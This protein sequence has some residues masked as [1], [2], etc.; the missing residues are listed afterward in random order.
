M[1][2]NPFFRVKKFLENLLRLCQSDLEE[3]TF[4]LENSDLADGIKIVNKQTNETKIISFE[5]KTKNSKNFFKKFKAN[6]EQQYLENLKRA[7]EKDLKKQQKELIFSIKTIKETLNYFTNNG[8]KSIIPD[9]SSFTMDILTIGGEINLSL[10]EIKVI[11]A[12]A[13]KQKSTFYKNNLKAQRQNYDSQNLIQIEEMEESLKIGSYFSKTGEILPNDN[14]EQFEQSVNKIFSSQLLLRINEKPKEDERAFTLK[15]LIQSFI[16]ELKI[17]NVIKKENDK[18][19][20]EESTLKQ[21]QVQQ[22]YQE[23]KSSKKAYN[24]Q[25]RAIAELKKYYKDNEIIKIHPDIEIFKKL[26]EECQLSAEQIEKITRLMKK[27]MNQSEDNIEKKYSEFL[28]LEQISIIKYAQKKK[29]EKSEQILGEILSN[30]ELMTN[31]KDAEEIIYLQECLQD[32]IKE[33]K[34]I[35]NL[36]KDEIHRL[37]YKNEV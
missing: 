3:I 34:Y 6:K 14:I 30:L 20:L 13:I 19:A 37:T 2:E 9:I 22:R 5:I 4:Q 8:L 23:L 10:D 33:L 28:T 15:E 1:V 32:N 29:L 21:I 25:M 35:L 7:F 26:L 18:K 11:I 16:E 24:L 12:T 31:T 27:K 36:S 17:K